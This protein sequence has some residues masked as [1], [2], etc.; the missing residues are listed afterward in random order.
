M[1]SCY[2]VDAKAEE[3]LLK[4]NEMAP[5]VRSLESALRFAE[6]EVASSSSSSPSDCSVVE[7]F[8]AVIFLDLTADL[9]LRISPTISRSTSSAISSIASSLLVLT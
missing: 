9:A 6:V 3:D 4:R 1:V 8:S 2:A 7:L 5:G